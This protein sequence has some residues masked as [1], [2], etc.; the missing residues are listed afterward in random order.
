M[1]GRALSSREAAIAASRVKENIRAI[2]SRWVET[3]ADVISVRRH[4][5]ADAF[6]HWLDAEC[7]LAIICA[8]PFFRNPQVLDV[9]RRPEFLVEIA[10]LAA[11]DVVYALSD[12]TKGG[13]PYYVGKTSDLRR[14]LKQHSAVYGTRSALAKRKM[15]IQARGAMTVVSPVFPCASPGEAD[16]LEGSLIRQWSR[17]L[18]NR[19]RNKFKPQERRYA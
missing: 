19:Q 2:Q 18:A 15:E 5:P 4:M 6:T 10:A 17:T 13:E 7:G 16:E 11:G 12:P 1:N 8:E 9:S 14:R 3:V